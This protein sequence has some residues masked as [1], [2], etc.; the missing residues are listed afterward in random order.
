MAPNFA[1]LP[2]DMHYGET[3]VTPTR[4]KDYLGLMEDDTAFLDSEVKDAIDNAFGHRDLKLNREVGDLSSEAFKLRLLAESPSVLLTFRFADVRS[5][6]DP[7]AI[8]ASRLCRKR[9]SGN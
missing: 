6:A 4:H 8:K 7:F 9:Q 5:A 1:E 2:G 3:N